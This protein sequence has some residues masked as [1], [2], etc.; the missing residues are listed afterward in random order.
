MS[1]S[2]AA[3]QNAGRGK[4]ALIAFVSTL[5]VFGWTAARVHYMFGGNWTAL[6]Y[7]GADLSVPRDLDARTYRVASVGYDGQF[8]RYL[9]HD[10]FLAKGYASYVDSPRLRFG[11]ILVPFL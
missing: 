1:A 3:G 6:F 4:C 11:R 7:T 5:L 8:Y 10:P 2:Q 9:A